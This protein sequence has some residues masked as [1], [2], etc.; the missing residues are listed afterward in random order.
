MNQ[1]YVN[2]DYMQRLRADFMFF[3]EHIL[4]LRHRSGKTIPFKLNKAQQLLWQEIRQQ[5]TQ[6]QVRLIILKGRQMGISSFIAALNF[7][8]GWSR[9]GQHAL[10][11]GA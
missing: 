8:Q 9:M 7:Y 4:K 10:I 6:S 5:Q 11:Y 2:K 1:K 3:T